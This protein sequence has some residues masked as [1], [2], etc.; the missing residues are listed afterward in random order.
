MATISTHNG[1][2]VKR[3]HN[4]RDKRVV[5]KEKHIDPDG[6]YEI[7]QDV[8]PRKAYQDA[9]G[10]AVTEYNKTQKRKDRRITDYYQ[11]ICKDKKK[12]VLY[13]MICGVY[14]DEVSV[15]NAYGI[16]RE[17][18]DGF[19]NRHSHIKVTG[20]YFHADE[21]SKYP[22]VHIDYFPVAEM[23]KGMVLQNS[24]AK[25]LEQEGF[26]PGKQY[27]SKNKE[28]AQISF[29]RSENAVLEC[30][31]NKY[32]IEVV[33]PQKDGHVKHLNTD[34]YKEQ[35]QI[36]EKIEVLTAEKTELTVQVGT[37]KTKKEKIESSQPMFFFNLL[38]LMVEFIERVLLP[39]LPNEIANNVMNI[40]DSKTYGDL[41]Q[42]IKN[43]IDKVNFDK[44][45]K[46]ESEIS[47]Y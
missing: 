6:W 11:K 46:D 24:L 16:L 1:S 21:E 20:I 45:F 18:A 41:K 32:G 3:K 38:K 44:D 40:L 26:T 31:C 19:Q 33:H 25:A 47:I 5:S 43:E 2:D 22:H 28:T 7:W 9:F 15:E 8:L 36:E 4:I 27:N 34:I 13:E 17:Y 23:E 30:I 39:F 14:G 37:L 12:H 35:K 10:E 29:Q 42:A